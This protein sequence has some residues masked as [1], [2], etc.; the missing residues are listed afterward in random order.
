[1]STTAAV[2]RGAGL[3]P[4]RFASILAS[5]VAAF[6]SLFV[7]RGAFGRYVVGL[8]CG[9]VRQVLWTSRWFN[10]FVFAVAT[11]FSLGVLAG[12]ALLAVALLG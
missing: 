12:G 2:R 7:G 1:M 3:T 6:L 8:F 4:A 10:A 9:G 5:H 11:A